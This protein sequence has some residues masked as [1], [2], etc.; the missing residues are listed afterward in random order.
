MLLEGGVAVH[1]SL[2]VSVQGFS[3]LRILHFQLMFVDGRE[4]VSNLMCMSRLLVYTRPRECLYKIFV[5]S[6]LYA[7][8]REDWVS[9]RELGR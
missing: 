5:H 7:A 2:P 9:Q 3:V 8:S 1:L 4:T 6:L